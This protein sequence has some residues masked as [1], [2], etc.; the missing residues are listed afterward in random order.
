MGFGDFDMTTNQIN[1]TANTQNG[2]VYK[3]FNS[4]LNTIPMFFDSFPR[5][6]MIV[7]GSDSA[8]HFIEQC[9]LMCQRKCED[10]CLKSHR[11]IKIYQGYVDKNYEILSITFKFYGGV[12]LESQIIIEDYVLG[13][14]YD[15][16]LLSRNIN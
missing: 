7:K 11:R 1:D 3:V 16:V 6:I 12:D 10:I 13:R 9:K 14:R 4:V 15:A 2:D 8:P 5:A